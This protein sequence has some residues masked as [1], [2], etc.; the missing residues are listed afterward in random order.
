MTVLSIVVL[1]YYSQSEEAFDC[2]NECATAVT[3]AGAVFMF[4]KFYYGQL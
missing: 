2:F 4:I 3:S 1:S